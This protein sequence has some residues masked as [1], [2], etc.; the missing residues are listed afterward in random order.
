MRAGVDNIS[1][2][3]CERLGSN[4]V[5]VESNV[6]MDAELDMGMMSPPAKYFS[7]TING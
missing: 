6:E 7:I 5:M 1:Q 3:C 2:D 4:F